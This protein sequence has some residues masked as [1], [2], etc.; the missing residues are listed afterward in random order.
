MDSGILYQ[1]DRAQAGCSR[2]EHIYYERKDMTFGGCIFSFAGDA[3][4]INTVHDKRLCRVIIAWNK[5]SR[6]IYFDESGN[7][8][9]FNKVIYRAAAV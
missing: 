6:G 1:F 4:I 2:I 9:T 3:V 8:R 5:E 7:H